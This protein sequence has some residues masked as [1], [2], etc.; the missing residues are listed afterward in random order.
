MLSVLCTGHLYPQEIFLILISV[1]GWVD[2]RA[3]VWPKGLCQFTR[4][5]HGLYPTP[6]DLPLTPGFVPSFS[7]AFL[8]WF[9]SFGFTGKNFVCISVPSLTC[10]RFQLTHIPNNIWWVLQLYRSQWRRSSAA[11][12]LRVWVRIPTGAWMFVCCECCVL[13]GRGLCDGLIARP[14]ESYRL[15]RVVVCD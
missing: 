4:T 2:P 8:K 9:L 12:L 14:E 13:S 15:W 1:R 7:W 10:Y 3:I 6:A 11:R 5:Y